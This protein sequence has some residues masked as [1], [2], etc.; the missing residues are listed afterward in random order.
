MSAGN[1]PSLGSNLEWVSCRGKG[2]DGLVQVQVDLRSLC[3]SGLML[4]GAS[5]DHA[6]RPRPVSMVPGVWV[7]G[8]DPQKL[9]VS[10]GLGLFVAGPS[11]VGFWADDRMISICPTR[12]QV[13]T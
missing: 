13:R 12:N 9:A 6:L 2:L 1:H 5:S 10:F 3:L 7:R 8:E 4:E 11:K